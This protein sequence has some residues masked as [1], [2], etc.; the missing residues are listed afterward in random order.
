VT[1]LSDRI[2][3]GRQAWALGRHR[4][5]G[6]GYKEKCGGLQSHRFAFSSAAMD[7]GMNLVKQRSVE[8]LMGAK[9]RSVLA[10][11]ALLA[12]KQRKC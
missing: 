6:R 8:Y 3:F 5:D 9:G 12:K 2:L 11:D 1:E 4:T 7:R 10:T